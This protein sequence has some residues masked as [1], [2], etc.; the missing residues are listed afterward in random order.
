VPTL[1]VVGDLLVVGETPSADVEVVEIEG[2]WLPATP[3][4]DVVAVP[5]DAPT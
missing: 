1:P 5:D 4:L 2:L 3:T